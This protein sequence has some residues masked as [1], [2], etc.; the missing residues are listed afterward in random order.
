[1]SHYGLRFVGTP[2]P[3]CYCPLLV[4]FPIF[5]NICCYKSDS[6]G[7]LPPWASSV[8]AKWQVF[9]LGSSRNYWLQLLAYVSAYS[10]GDK[11]DN[12]F[13]VALFWQPLSKRK[14]GW[15]GEAREL[16]KHNFIGL[17]TQAIQRS[18]CRQGCWWCLAVCA[19]QGAPWCNWQ[20]QRNLLWLGK[21]L[22]NFVTSQCRSSLQVSWVRKISQSS[23]QD[24]YGPFCKGGWRWAR[25]SS[26]SANTIYLLVTN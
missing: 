12:T 2:K 20:T 6:F 14:D 19:Q 9:Q 10:P 1:M 11:K 24:S 23:A 26:L 7:L 3:N 16:R 8:V 4:L 17:R 21:S 15:D 13:H 5:Y 18:W 22:W 25:S